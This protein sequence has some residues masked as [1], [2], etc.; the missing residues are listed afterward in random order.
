MPPPVDF[1]AVPLLQPMVAALRM[2]CSATLS[3]VEANTIP[4]PQPKP[5]AMG[6]RPVIAG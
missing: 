1:D 6:L 3:R 4:L 2:V 5:R